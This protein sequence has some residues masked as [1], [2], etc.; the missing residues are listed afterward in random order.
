MVRRD[1]EYLWTIWVH[2][3]ATGSERRTAENELPRPRIAWSPDSTALVA[4]LTRGA[5][6]FVNLYR[7]PIQA[8]AVP[9][10]LTD[11]PDYGQFPLAWSAKARGIL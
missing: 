10:R 6:Q 1:E 11:Q 5:S 7:L 2:D 4:S 8:Y 9:E 3:L